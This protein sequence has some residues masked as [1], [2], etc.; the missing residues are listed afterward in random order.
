MRQFCLELTQAFSFFVS[1]F[2]GCY[3]DVCTD[4]L[5]RLSPLGRYLMANCLDVFNGSVRVARF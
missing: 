2:A 5:N 4:Q 1:A 3:I